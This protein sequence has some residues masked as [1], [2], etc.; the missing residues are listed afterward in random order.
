MSAIQKEKS[1]K[2]LRVF[3]SYS[4]ADKTYARKLRSSLSQRLNLQIFT[5]ETLSAGEDWVSQLKD[6]LSQCDIFVVLLSP[7]SVD[8]KWLLH[9]LGAAWALNKPIIPI[10]TQP[11]IFSK[12]PLALRG[13]KFVEMKDIEKPEVMG[14]ILEHY[15]EMVASNSVDKG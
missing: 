13:T 7:D 9:E 15:E 4:E 11:E 1:K 14:E 2:A 8:S 5:A 3:L 10:V 6:E 12:I